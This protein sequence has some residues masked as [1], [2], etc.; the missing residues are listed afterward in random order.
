M[1]QDQYFI[2]LIQ[3]PASSIQQTA[4]RERAGGGMMAEY[5]TIFKITS[6]LIEGSAAL[7]E[8][9]IFQ[10]FSGILWGILR[11]LI[12]RKDSFEIL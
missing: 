4:E 6:I 8:N 5:P 12:D 10:L 9:W 2:A 1:L 11:I 7:M 3:H